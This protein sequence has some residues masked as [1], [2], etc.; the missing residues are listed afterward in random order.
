MPPQKPRNLQDHQFEPIQDAPPPRDSLVMDDLLDVHLTIHA[1]LGRCRMSVRDVLDL[2]QGSIVQLD[3][4]AGEMTD[5]FL[6]H[7][8]LA[9]GE[10]VVIGDTLHVRIGEILGTA[11][12]APD[13][14]E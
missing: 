7:Q 4:Q 1:D 14:D 2:R 8:P 3:K 13:D 9:K 12:K 5:V 10:V 6:N 11:E